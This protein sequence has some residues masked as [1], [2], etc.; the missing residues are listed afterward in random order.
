MLKIKNYNLS[1]FTFLLLLLCTFSLSADLTL[2]NKL[3]WFVVFIFNFLFFQINIKLK[4]LIL[5]IIAIGA[6]YIQLIFNQYVFSEEFFLNCL[7]IL[8]IM[9]F[10]ELKNKDNKLSFSLI[11]LI[12]S[13][14]SLIKGQDILSTILSFTIVILVVINMYLIQQK[15]LLDFNIK[16]IFKYLGFGLSI[17]PFIII[18]YLAFPRAEI[19]FRLF[20]PASSSLGIPDSINLGS[21]SEFSNSDEDVFTLINN[22]FKKE[23]LYFRVKIFDYMEDD[24]SWR[25]SSSYYLFDK[26]KSSFKVKDGRDLNQTY[27]II[28]EPFKKK[29]IPSLKNSKLITNDI[30][31]TKDYFNQSFVSRELIDRKKKLIFKM[32]KSDYSLDNPL[33]NYYTLLPENISP[34][35]K[36]WVDKNNVSTKEEFIEKIYKRF[37]DGSYFYNLSPQIN[38]NNKYENFFFN[39]KEG[40]CEYYA[41]TFVLLTRLAQIPSR[42]VTGYYGGDLNEIGNFFQFKQKD[43]HAWAEVWFDERGWVRIDPTRAIPNSNIRN[44]L[45]NYF[46]NNDKSSSTIFSN[47]FFKIMNFY[48]NYVDFVWTQ[49]L[50]SYDDNERKNFIK[51]L[52]NLNFSKIVVWIFVPILLFVSIKLL[53]NFNSTNVMRLK[54]AFI[55]LGKKRKLQIKNSDT[56]QE[57]YLKL[58]EKDKSKYKNFFKFY[59]KQIY[60][61]NQISFIKVLKLVF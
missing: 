19:N 47:N 45:N 30:Q 6:I 11:C 8:L 35:I 36:E 39:S 42:I 3:F 41:G 12:I 34:K 25:P 7:A 15:E 5:G 57:I 55:L 28:L 14:A 24:K 23:E 59:E 56:I 13:V 43:T 53:Y 16:N 31:I 54:L 27:Q 58:M 20:N 29:W 37:S 50:L 1:V 9:K 48:F 60:S 51:E 33:K 52:L 18:F 44:S 61:N 40:Y 26:Y 32:N 38:S 17:F 21:F 22:N 4:S 49:H 2:N 10:S 46:V